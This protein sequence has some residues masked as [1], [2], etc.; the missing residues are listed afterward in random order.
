MKMALWHTYNVVSGASLSLRLHHWDDI[1]TE[2][3][4]LVRSSNRTPSSR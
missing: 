3:D 1:M 2:D 4:S